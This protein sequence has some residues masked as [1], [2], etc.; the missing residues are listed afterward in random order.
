MKAQISQ[1]YSTI[2][3]YLVFICSYYG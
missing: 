2:F 3:S 1:D